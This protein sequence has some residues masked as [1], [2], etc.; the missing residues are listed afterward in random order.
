MAKRRA[1]PA[2]VR[3]THRPARLRR[4][5]FHG[6]VGEFVT[7]IEPHTEA[8]AN[9]LLIHFLVA[10]GFVA[11]RRAFVLADGAR[12]FPNLFVIV[13]GE[14]ARA[15]KGTAW[16]R[17][18]AVFES[19]SIWPK[20]R[21]MNGLS[22]GEGIIA[23]V[24]ETEPDKR[25]LV[26]QTEFGSVLQVMER[27]GNTLSATLRDAWDGSDLRI[28]TRNAPISASGEHICVIGHI[29]ADELMHRIELTE[30]W[31]GFANRFLWC[32]ASR[33]RLLPHG[34]EVPD[35]IMQPLRLRLQALL[36]KLTRHRGERRIEWSSRAAIEW[37]R[38]YA[39][40]ARTSSGLVGA[41]TSR[42]EPQ[43]VRLALLYAL[44]DG[45]DDIR[46]EHLKAAVAVWEYCEA[47]ARYVFGSALG[48]PVADQILAELR[49]TPAGMTRTQITDYLG[50]HR[51]RAQ[52]ATALAIL[53][54]SSVCR[55]QVDQTRG[56]PV[57]RW[58]FL[59]DDG[60][61]V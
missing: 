2:G 51:S 49:R 58:F 44:L 10:F 17:I 29:T 25:L 60:V 57:E 3:R 11:G 34:G 56:R 37:E 21:L 50:R 59:S 13:V 26:V 20:E 39:R 45:S 31:N 16:N 32:I 24:G 6:L 1:S 35:S 47:S 8:D 43:V 28:M 41:V 30:L 53:E 22:S 4:E 42:A 55:K 12:H 36:V 15:R 19:L 23:Q 46:V 9:A 7:A 48:D 14:T 18:R 38:V 40:L 52:I 5:A 33:A 27:N 61:E 54:S